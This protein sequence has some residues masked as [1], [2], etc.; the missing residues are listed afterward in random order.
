MVGGGGLAGVTSSV[1]RDV[2]KKKRSLRRGGGKGEGTSLV[3]GREKN[4]SGAV[5]EPADASF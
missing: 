2:P 4:C 5:P 3:D 1:G